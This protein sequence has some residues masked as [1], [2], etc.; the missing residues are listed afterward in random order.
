MKVDREEIIQLEHIWKFGTYKSD[1]F[2]SEEDKERFIRK[3]RAGKYIG[4]KD[5]WPCI[6][7]QGLEALFSHYKSKLC[8][9]F[10]EQTTLF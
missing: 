10:F 5:Q 6:R 1:R 7:N 4:V 8:T 2:Y 3:M 9:N